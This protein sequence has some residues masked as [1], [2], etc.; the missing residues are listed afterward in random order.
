[1]SC[2]DL[3]VGLCASWGLRERLLV[4]GKGPVGETVEKR[5]KRLKA[6]L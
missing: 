6:G 1:V 3:A 2:S 4:L 5:M